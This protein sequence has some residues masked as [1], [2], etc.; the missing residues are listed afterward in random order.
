MAKR[1]RKPDPEKNYFTEIHE[2]AVVDYLAT[3]DIIEKNRIFNTQLKA[4]FDKMILGLYGNKKLFR[5]G[6]SFEEIRDDTLADL[7][8]K[9][10]KFKPEKGCKAY[11]YYGTICKNYMLCNKIKDEKLE[12]INF[13][14][15]DNA[16]VLNNHKTYSYDLNVTEDSFINEMFT[17]LREEIDWVLNYKKLKPPLTDKERIIGCTLIDIFDN[18]EDLFGD[19]LSKNNKKF[20]KRLLSLY[21]AELTDYKPRDIKIGLRRFKVLYK[22]IKEE[23]LIENE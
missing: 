21:F 16:G 8:S 9:M 13:S 7:I 1:G 2:K 11:S 3:E 12:K 10:D 19:A 17:G 22:L 15:E 5:K 6:L 14:Y 23:K 18:W 20:D 4:V